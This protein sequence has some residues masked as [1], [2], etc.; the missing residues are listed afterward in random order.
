MWEGGYSSLSTS[1]H[2]K[3][4]SPGT[5]STATPPPPPPPRPP[6]S[7]SSQPPTAAAT[8]GCVLPAPAGE[9]PAPWAAG[10]AGRAGEAGEGETPATAACPSLLLSGKHT[11]M[12]G[13]GLG[14]WRW[15]WVLGCGGVEGGGA[16]S[17]ALFLCGMPVSPLLWHPGQLLP[18][19]VMVA[20]AVGACSVWGSVEMMSWGVPG[21]MQGS[22]SCYQHESMIHNVS[23]TR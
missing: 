3:R 10:A 17:W 20:V 9:W 15:R 18:A 21:I 13:L 22:P 16:A 11:W 6:P 14:L 1:A 5:R 2:V 12:A 4:S 19:A 23:C 7:H 8:G